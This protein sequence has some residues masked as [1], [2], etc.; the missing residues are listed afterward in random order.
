MSRELGIIFGAESVRALLAGQKTQTRRLVKGADD[1]E[2]PCRYRAG[3]RLWVRETWAVGACAEGFKPRELSER[4]W[5]ADNGGVWFV[6][7]DPKTPIS[8]RGTWRTPLFMPRW[9]SRITLEVVSVRRENLLEIT[10][11]DAVDEGLRPTEIGTY[12]VPIDEWPGFAEFGTARQAYLFAWDGIN[13]KRVAYRHDADPRVD[14]I[15][16]RR[17]ECRR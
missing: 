15:E 17:I 1:G 8:P 4:V 12:Q 2:A 3:D 9:V 6:G 13:G 5:L 14:R 11:S 7:T 10:E 16:F